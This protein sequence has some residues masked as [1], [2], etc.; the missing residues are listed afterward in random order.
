M[1]N[2][3]TLSQSLLSMDQM[4]NI[5]SDPTTNFDS[6]KLGST[7]AKLN[8]FIID[9][10]QFVSDSYPNLIERFNQSYLTSIE[11]ADI[12][13]KKYIDINQLYS[14]LSVTPFTVQL[15]S[16]LSLID[17]YFTSMYAAVSSGFCSLYTD[18][19]ITIS[20]LLSTGSA[21]I[22]ELKNFNLSSILGKLQTVDSLIKTIIDKF[23]SQI[24][25]I[26][27]G[28]KATL[29]SI[30]NRN[31][32]NKLYENFSQVSSLF[33]KDS[34][35]SLKSTAEKILTTLAEQFKEITPQILNFILFKACTLSSSIEDTLFKPV[36]LLTGQI[37]AFNNNSTVLKNYSTRH[38]INAINAGANRYSSDE[39]YSTQMNLVSSVNMSGEQY[40]TAMPSD[41][42]RTLLMTLSDQ[43]NQFI[44][45]SPQVLNMHKQ[46]PSSNPANNIPGAGWR[47]VH[48]DVWIYL[49]RVAQRMGVKFYINS[50]YR[51]EN[52][53]SAVGGANNSLHMSGLAV[54]VSM[55]GVDRTSFIK[56]CSQESFKG[57]GTYPSFIHVDLGNRRTWGT[58]D[59]HLLAMH[60][61]DR[62]R[63]G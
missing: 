23:V 1:Q 56:Y 59:S 11:L 14:E 36:N 20:T 10:K 7:T 62:F 32:F 2:T 3:N 5:S 49:M 4:T 58:H 34:I 35:E 42:E 18:N 29:S 54:D 26:F 51:N 17:G 52:K 47:K 53:N 40:I 60:E 31:A 57:I 61:Q 50:A 15:K 63:K 24:K 38:R 9:N 39:I 43:G 45:F 37:S 6:E 16:I 21:L 44:E 13:N 25:S 48:P 19:S 12:M 8:K 33:E 28:L 27:E 22:S 55:S 46:Y 41:L 30:G